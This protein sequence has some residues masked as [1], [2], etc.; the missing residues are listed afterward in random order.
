MENRSLL[1]LEKRDE[2]WRM[3]RGTFIRFML[4]VRDYYK[5]CDWCA[6]LNY[7]EIRYADISYDALK[8]ACLFFGRYFS[9]SETLLLAPVQS[10]RGVV[11][12]G[13][14]F[15]IYISEQKE[16]E[17]ILRSIIMETV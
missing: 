10:R 6:E 13:T 3:D 17:E 9:D 7:D 15:R 1:L 14:T 11:K 16:E 12:R 5:V 4:D 2:F 8:T